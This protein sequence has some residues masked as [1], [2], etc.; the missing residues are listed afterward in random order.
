MD[1]VPSAR[2]RQ[3]RLGGWYEEPA[4]CRLGLHPARGSACLAASRRRVPCLRGK[5]WRRPS[6]LWVGVWQVTALLR[7]PEPQRGKSLS[8]YNVSCL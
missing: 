2:Q 7:C 5:D 6:R 4:R 8:L 3:S 1:P